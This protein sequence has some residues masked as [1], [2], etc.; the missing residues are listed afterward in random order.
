M[1]SVTSQLR[2]LERKNRIANGK[3]PKVMALHEGVVVERINGADEVV[4]REVR[5][6]PTGGWQERRA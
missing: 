6:H 4:Q 1:Q 5:L 2:R 3:R